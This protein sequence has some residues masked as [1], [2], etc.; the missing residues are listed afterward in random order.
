M[1]GSSVRDNASLDAWILANKDP[2]RALPRE[3]C[4]ESSN[5]VDDIVLFNHVHF[6]H[7]WCCLTGLWS[8]SCSSNFVC[9]SE[10]DFA[11]TGM[12]QSA[13]ETTIDSASSPRFIW[14]AS[15]LFDTRLPVRYVCFIGL[16]YSEEYGVFENE[17]ICNRKWIFSYIIITN[18][19]TYMHPT[20][21][22]WIL[23]NRNRKYNFHL[24]HKQK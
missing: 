20:Y 6:Y 21:H 2:L 24:Y 3:V 13:T 19:R 5:G 4:E 17:Y 11:R 22:W 16:L 12:V 9:V 23:E 10:V 7:V 18:V 15:R 1:S 14:I 8:K